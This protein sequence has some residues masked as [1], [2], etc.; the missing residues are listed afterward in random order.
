MSSRASLLNRGPCEPDTFYSN[1]TYMLSRVFSSSRTPLRFNV[2][3]ESNRTGAGLIGA[4]QYMKYTDQ[5]RTRQGESISRGDTDFHVKFCSE[6]ISLP[7]VLRIFEFVLKKFFFFLQPSTQGEPPQCLPSSILLDGKENDVLQFQWEGRLF[8]YRLKQTMHRDSAGK[9][10]FEEYFEALQNYMQAEKLISTTPYL[11]EQ[12]IPSHLVQYKFR[13]FTE[14]AQLYS[15]GDKSLVPLSAANF[16]PLK[17]WLDKA[18]SSKITLSTDNEY[19]RLIM[20][21]PGVPEENIRIITD[22]NYLLVLAQP[23]PLLLPEGTPL[24][25]VKRLYNT[26][27]EYFSREILLKKRKID[28]K[29]LEVT[30]LNGKAN[31]IFKLT[32]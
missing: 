11:F 32:L 8:E 23:Q 3:I 13:S 21:V 16:N 10:K 26:R 28:P 15:P 20:D 22:L 30:C 5:L 19:Y 27:S 24:E 17:N 29:S 7:L 18:T 12:D 31:I 9:G 2:Y 1:C 4:D 6:T 25:N 14:N